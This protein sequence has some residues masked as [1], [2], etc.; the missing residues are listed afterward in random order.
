MIRSLI[1]AI[2][3]TIALGAGYSLFRG[4]REYMT[5]ERIEPAENHD[6]LVER[7]ESMRDAGHEVGIWS[8]Q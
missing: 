1:Q 7:M 4:V 8:N 5:R 2:I 6:A 3:I